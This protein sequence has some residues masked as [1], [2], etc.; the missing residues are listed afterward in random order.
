VKKVIV[1]IIRDEWHYVKKCL[2]MKEEGVGLYGWYAT[3][4]AVRRHST[5]DKF[6]GSH[7]CVTR[8]R[9]DL[10]DCFSH[11]WQFISLFFYTDL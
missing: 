10:G 3:G 2:R 6:G 11:K 7:F 8:Y 1:P 5:L 4:S 9:Q